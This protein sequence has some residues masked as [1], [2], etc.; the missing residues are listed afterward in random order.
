MGLT[1]EQREQVQHQFERMRSEAVAIGEQIIVREAAL[2]A[3]FKSGSADGGSIDTS[4]A[5]LASLYG[6]LRAVHLRTH[7]ATRATLTDAQLAAYQ[8]L[9]GYDRA[10]AAPVHKH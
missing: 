9:R 1:Q 6:Q 7:L 2:D 4:T 10:G 5:E 8:G 3:L